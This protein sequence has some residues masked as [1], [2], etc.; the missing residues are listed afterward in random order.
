MVFIIKIAIVISVLEKMQ[1]I[2]KKQ[3]IIHGVYHNVNG[4]IHYVQGS[5]TRNNDCYNI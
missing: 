3:I 1:I 5:K 4:L 2:Q